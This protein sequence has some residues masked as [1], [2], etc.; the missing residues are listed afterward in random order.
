LQGKRRPACEPALPLSGIAA[1]VP[2]ARRAPRIGADC[3]SDDRE[4]SAGGSWRR[5]SSY[6]ICGA[7]ERVLATSVA[8][9]PAT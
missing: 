4:Q 8:L 9:E 3:P 2:A 7:A 6:C 1:V 5:L